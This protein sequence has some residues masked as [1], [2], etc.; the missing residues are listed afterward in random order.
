MEKEKKIPAE[1]GEE[2]K[3]KE[4][5]VEKVES[6]DLIENIKSMPK[7]LLLVVK[8]PVSSFNEKN[9][10]KLDD[11]KYSGIMATLIIL[12][13]SVLAFVGNIYNIVHT[14]EKVMLK[15]GSMSKW[16][17]DRLEYYD[18]VEMF[19]EYVKFYGAI[20]LIVTVVYYIAGLI[21]KKE[22]SFSKMLGVVS[23]SFFPAFL[24]MLILVPILFEGYVELG[25]AGLML[26][27]I[28][29]F[30]LVSKFISDEFKLKD[31]KYIYV[32]LACIAAVLMI[33]FIIVANVLETMLMF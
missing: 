3:V 19:I 8:K 25:T 1:K 14:D 17:W 15:D 32:N 27:W 7:F 26:S 6:T 21:L 2:I 23:A 30:M 29:P 20:I 28:F 24:S 5:E 18:L 9:S 33:M 22:L 13:M 10:K 31:A 16:V 11:I 12:I 4:K